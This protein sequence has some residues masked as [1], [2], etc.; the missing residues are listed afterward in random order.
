M[1]ERLISADSHVRITEDWV[2]ER[3]PKSALGSYE[4]AVRT[5]KEFELEQ[6]LDRDTLTTWDVALAYVGGDADHFESRGF[7]FA[8]RFAV[9]G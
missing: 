1:D 4:N 2:K 8:H 9:C 3:L 6:R 7:G 5:L